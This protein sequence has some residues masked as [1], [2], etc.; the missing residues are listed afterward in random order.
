MHV[1]L[2]P[3]GSHGDVHPFL[4]L[5]LA[6]RARGHRVTFLVNEYFGPLVRRLGFELVAIGAASLFEDVLRDP[7]LWHPRRAFTVVARGVI[8][9]AR[10]AY[11]RLAELKE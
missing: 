11:P 9:H 7:E 1:L 5:G 3:V 6:L 8:E 2:V 4:G 10:L